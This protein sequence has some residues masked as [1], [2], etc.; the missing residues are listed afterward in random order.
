[1][2][3]PAHLPSVIASPTTNH[4]SF[5]AVIGVGVLHLL[6]FYALLS[7]LATRAVQS[8]P[9]IIDVRILES[10]PPKQ[11]DLPPPAP[12]PDMTQP[13]IDIVPPPQIRIATPPAT[14]AITVEH[15]IVPATISPR[16]APPAPPVAQPPLKPTPATAIAHTHTIP[17]Y[18]PLSRRLGEQG[19][20]ELKL[21]VGADG[22]VQTAELLKSSGSERLDDAARSWVASH[23]RYHPAK[24]DGRAVPS[25]TRV[26]VV[27]DLKITR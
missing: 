14:A 15:K 2:L 7:G 21:T 4:R 19:T 13:S 8:L 18:P 11:V 12:L 9:H 23:W 17:P 24:R 22:H 26:H 1:V 3:R 25:E 5:A 10:A 20:V 6:F 27:F 16:V